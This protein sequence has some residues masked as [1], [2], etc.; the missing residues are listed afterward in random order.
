MATTAQGQVTI[1][2]YNDA[3]TL[4]GYIGANLAKTQM[5]SADN[6][7]YSPDWSTTNMVLTPSLYVAGTNT[8]VITSSAVQS[9]KWYDGAGTMA[10]TA[11]TNYALSGAKSH[12]LTIKKN[13]LAGLS[14]KDYRCEVVYQDAGSGLEVTYDMTISLSRVQN[15]AC[16]VSLVVTTPS[17]NIFK[18][19]EINSLTACAEL[20]R[21]STA[22]TTNVTYQWFMMDPFVTSDQGGGIGWYLLTNTP[23]MYTGVTTAT[24]TLYAAAVDSYTTIKCVATDTKAGS[25]TYNSK[26]SDVASYVDLSDPMTVVITSTGGDVFKNGEGS[27][28]LTAHAYQSGNEIDTAGAGT[29]TWTKYG[30]DGNIDTSWET[31]GHKTGKSI[32]V[33]S[34]EVYT[35]ATFMV[36]V[37]IP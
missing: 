6:N 20:R 3:I 18:N 15:G 30:S 1:V 33:T 12:I 28:V 16:T 19:D 7:S 34:S 21:G 5:Y 27:T 14:G 9:V 23:G 31:S 35:K 32:T 29:Y 26:F 11:D 22:D 4:T 10:I 25:S 8:D 2:D 13:V 24:L 17:G 36:E 37:V